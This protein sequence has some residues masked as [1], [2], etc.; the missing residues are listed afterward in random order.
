MGQYYNI[1]TKTNRK[2]GVY[3][4][5]DRSIKKCE[6]DKAEYVVAKITEHSWIGNWTMDS[7]SAKLFKHPMRVAWV[8]DYADQLDEYDIINKDLDY[9]TAMKLYKI[10][11]NDE[12]T[13]FHSLMVTE[14]E[15]SGTMLVNH[16]KKLYLK[17][18]KYIKASK[19][20]ELD[21]LNEDWCAHPLSL[22]TA[23]GNGLG[24]GDY[25][26]VNEDEVGIWAFDVVSFENEEDE[27]ILANRGY[28]EF[29]IR[30]NETER[31][32]EVD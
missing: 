6:G 7:L 3:T 16:S 4:V 32:E 22:L 15:Y 13:K 18:D 25:S 12:G 14:F 10:A 11:W 19:Y 1:V 21:E 17:M 23:I 29:E 31:N 24:G 20:K 8:G 26:G 28:K 9:N 30:F 2:N 27:G 5:Y